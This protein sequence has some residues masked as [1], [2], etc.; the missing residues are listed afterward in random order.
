MKI[1]ELPEL[2]QTI[3][4]VQEFVQL[5]LVEHYAVILDALHLKG[6][7]GYTTCNKVYRE[8]YLWDTLEQLEEVLAA[9]IRQDIQL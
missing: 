6:R 9:E 4:L 3:R 1:Y 8:E 5:F 7:P 2:H